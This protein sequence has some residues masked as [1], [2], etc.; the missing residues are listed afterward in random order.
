MTESKL[1]V[2]NEKCDCA[3]CTDSDDACHMD[4]APGAD[5]ECLGCLEARHEQE[6]REVLCL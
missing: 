5:M 6:E 1:I 3:D 2:E 4:C